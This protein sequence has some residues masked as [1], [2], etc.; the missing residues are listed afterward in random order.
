MGEADAFAK[1]DRHARFELS[2]LQRRLLLDDVS[3]QLALAG[4]VHHVGLLQLVLMT[5]CL[6]RQRSFVLGALGRHEAIQPQS[7]F[8][9]VG[10]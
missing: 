5:R 1:A 3:V 4:E 2:L 8:D 10:D 6:A 7:C 9:G